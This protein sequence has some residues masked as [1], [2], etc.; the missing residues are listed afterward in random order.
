MRT[1]TFARAVAVSGAVLLAATACGGGS[2]SD[3]AAATGG[4][5]GGSKQVN[6]YGTDGNMGNALGEDFTEQ[7]ALAGMKGTAAPHRAGRATSRTGCSR[8]TPTCRTTTT[9]ASPT[10]R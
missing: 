9:P 8:S 2:D 5:D 1:G 3:D 6:V 10:T 7:G 4:S